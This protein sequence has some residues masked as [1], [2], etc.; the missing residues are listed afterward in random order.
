MSRGGRGRRDDISISASQPPPERPGSQ[1]TTGM[2]CLLMRTEAS[3]GLEA[4]VNFQLERR[5]MSSKE[6]QSS[7]L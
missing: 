5:R 6:A 3:A 7:C 1:S 4:R 2:T